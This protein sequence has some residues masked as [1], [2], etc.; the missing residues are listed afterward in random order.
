M[1]YSEGHPVRLVGNRLILDFLNTADWN[2]EGEVVHEKCATRDDIHLWLDAAGLPRQVLRGSA[3]EFR[4]LRG[5]LRG[6][7]LEPPAPD[8]LAALN[9]ALMTFPPSSVRRDGSWVV[10]GAKTPLGALL[11]ASALNLLIDPRDRARLKICP[12]NDCGWMFIDETKNSRR[13]WCS[14]ETCG[15]RAKVRRNYDKR[16]RGAPAAG[17]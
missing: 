3:A 1:T 11:A 15:N 7:F 13:T 17:R 16:R 4:Q 12:G 14:M 10:A 6:L 9:R 8:A 5:E 2:A